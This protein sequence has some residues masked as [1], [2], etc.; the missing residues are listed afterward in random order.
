M[1]IAYPDLSVD[2]GFLAREL[3]MTQWNHHYQFNS[4]FWTLGVEVHFYLLA[5]L[6]V[7]GFQSI[8][9]QWVYWSVALYLLV[10]LGLWMYSKTD[11]FVTWDMRSIIGGITHFVIGIVCA[12]YKQ[13]IIAYSNKKYFLTIVA[14]L[15][16]FLIG[17][18]NHNYTINLKMTFISNL[19]GVGLIFLHVMIE[20]RKIELNFLLKILLVLGV[21][22]YGIYAWHGLLIVNG[23]FADSLA[24]H[25]TTTIILAY[26]TYMIVER[27]LL[28]LKQ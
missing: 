11:F 7:F 13:Q 12:S 17:Y 26:I 28:K 15:V 4:V 8:F 10:F 16:L 14:I 25:T 6:L 2:L 23:I 5:P 3:L 27:P 21:L 20:E 24:L 1:L 9:K 22:S 19:I 18:F